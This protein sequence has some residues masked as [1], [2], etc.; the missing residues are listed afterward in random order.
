MSYGAE[1]VELSKLFF[2][3][4]IS[5]DEEAKQILSEEQVPE[6]LKAF[7]QELNGLEEFFKAEEIQKAIKAVQKSTGHKG[8][9]LFMPIRVAV[10][11][12]AHGPDLPKTIE[13]LGKEKINSRLE[14]LIG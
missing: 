14:A 3:D 13:L 4:S 7:L 6:V 1:I 11:G 5:Y 12:Q 2:T 9:K 10:T 8:K